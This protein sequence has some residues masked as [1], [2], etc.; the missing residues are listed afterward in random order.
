MSIERVKEDQKKV[1]V[2]D[3]LR[4]GPLE[5]ILTCVTEPRNTK[6]GDEI[7]RKILNSVCT[8]KQIKRIISKRGDLSFKMLPSPKICKPAESM[9]LW[10]LSFSLSDS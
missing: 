2:K 4:K 8:I 5:C 3:P 6:E 10:M 9:I 1:S 7:K